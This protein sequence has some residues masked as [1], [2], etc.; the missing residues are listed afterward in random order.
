MIEGGLPRQLVITLPGPLAASSLT[1]NASEAGG[2]MAPLMVVA[3]STVLTAQHRIVAHP[4][5]GRDKANGQGRWEGVINSSL[6]DTTAE[7]INRRVHRAQA[8]SCPVCIDL[9]PESTAD[10]SVRVKPRTCAE[11]WADNQ[12]TTI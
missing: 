10:T 2:T 11:K 8:A 5:C 3:C 12:N 7:N 9:C 6:W 1:Q 4:S